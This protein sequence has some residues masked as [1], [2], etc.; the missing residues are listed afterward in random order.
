M[1]LFIAVPL[2][3]E[4]QDRAAACL[5]RDLPGV[6]PVAPALLHVTL[7]FLGSTPDGLLP[8]VVEAARA[9]AT[10]EQPFELAFDRGG[11]F[12]ATGRPRTLWLGIGAGA[13]D[14]ARLAEK[15]AAALRAGG[16]RSDDRPFSPHLTVARVRE[17]ASAA[18]AGAAAG[19][20]QAPEAPGLWTAVDRIALIESI[21]SPRGPHYRVRALAPL[22]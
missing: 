5:P 21:L 8:A 3:P 16:L 17:T 14:L 10:G 9:A 6:K 22:G 2:H 7:A 11:R 15:L 1:R 19:A 18:E 12:P 13:D 4:V 20:L